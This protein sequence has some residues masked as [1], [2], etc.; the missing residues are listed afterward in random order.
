MTVQEPGFW[1]SDNPVECAEQVVKSLLFKVEVLGRSQGDGEE[2]PIFSKALKQPRWILKRLVKR[3][4]RR[5][6]W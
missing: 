1:A 4:R 5:W 6:K 2:L 3:A